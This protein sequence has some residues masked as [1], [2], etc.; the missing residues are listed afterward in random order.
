MLV[1]CKLT[2]VYYLVNYYF[3]NI[4]WLFR[5]GGMGGRETSWSAAVLCRLDRDPH[6]PETCFRP[7]WSHT[8]VKAPEDWRSPRWSGAQ[9][10]TVHHRTT[11][12]MV[13]MVFQLLVVAG[14]PSCFST[15]ALE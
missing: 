4:F 3:K 7:D 11:L 6:A 13:S 1:S 10:A 9:L 14:E 5:F 8:Q 2:E 12:Q 15:T